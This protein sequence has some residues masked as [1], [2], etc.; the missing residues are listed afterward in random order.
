ML[1]IVMVGLPAR[2]KTYTAR[3]IVRYLSWKGVK[4]KVFNVGTF[5]RKISGANVPHTFFDPSNTEGQTARRKAAQDAMD[6]MGTVVRVR[7]E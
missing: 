5:R 2:G 1:A 7:I 3:K 6:A 4:T